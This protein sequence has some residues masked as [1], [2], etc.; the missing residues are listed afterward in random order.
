LKRRKEV[1]FL[2]LGDITIEAVIG[3]FVSNENAKTE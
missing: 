3:F 1:E 2:V